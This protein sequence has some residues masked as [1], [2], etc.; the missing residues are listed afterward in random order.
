MAK[1]RENKKAR[2]ALEEQSAPTDAPEEGDAPLAVRKSDAQIT[3][4]GAADDGDNEETEGDAEGS[5]AAESEEAPAPGET[6]G[7][8]VAAAQLGTDR[9]VMAGFFAA[10]ILGGYVLGRVI[11]GLWANLA[12][13]DWFGQAVPWLAAVP[14]ED[15]SAYGTVVGGIIALIVV[16]RA[17]RKP[18]L[19]AWCDEVAAELSKVKWPTRKEVSNSTLVVI[20]ASAIATI[21]LALLD[22]LWAFVT[23]IV[24][25]DGS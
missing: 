21:Y 9:Y 24:Y 12:N 11:H 1:E 22:R 4:S 10:A 16:I 13:R 8:A 6:E 2:K 18:D 19:R 25:G 17:Y 15:K 23:N 5:G 3:E 7:E 14:D 20:A